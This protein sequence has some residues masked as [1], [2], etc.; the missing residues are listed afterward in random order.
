M[1]VDVTGAG[2]Y[3]FMASIAS[4][5]GSRRSIAGFK[6]SFVINCVIQF[7]IIAPFNVQLWSYDARYSTRPIGSNYTHS[8]SSLE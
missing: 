2:M 3:L 6:K 7:P 1:D 8:C 4:P 5:A